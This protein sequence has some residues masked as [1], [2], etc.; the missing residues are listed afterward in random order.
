MRNNLDPL[1]EHTNE[2]LW[3]A[4]EEVQLKDTIKNL[5]GKMN[6]EL[7]ES[8]LNLSVGQ[9]QL[10]CLARAILKKNQI[11]I[12]DKATSNVDP[13]TDELI[14]TKIR[15]KFAHCTVLT[16][17]HS[18]SSVINCQRITVLDS[19]RL[20]ETGQPNDLLQNRNSLCYKMMQQLGKDEVAVLPEREKQDRELLLKSVSGFS[21]KISIWDLITSTLWPKKPPETKLHE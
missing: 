16:I 15:E 21:H 18:L 8:G 20:K 12:M 9:R 7:A 5:P 3:N 13:R 19:G 1:N 4:L 6:T 11:L 17:T 14:Q 10:V 2:E